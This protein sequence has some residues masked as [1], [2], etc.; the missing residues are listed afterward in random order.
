MTIYQTISAPLDY[1]QIERGVSAAQI[2]DMIGK[3]VISRDEVYRAVPER[4][5]KR[6]LAEKGD[7]RIEE[8]DAIARLMRIN[9]LAR[10]AFGNEEQAQEFLDLPNPILGNRV[11]R[12]M[13]LTDAGA[14][15][16]EAILFRFVYGDYT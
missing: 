16:V 8:A 13:A 11:P 5:F 2:Q 6:R 7:L 9:E 3:G 12:V 15:E 10:W 4:T 1:A 14:R